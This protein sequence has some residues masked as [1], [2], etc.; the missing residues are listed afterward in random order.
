[1]QG[2]PLYVAHFPLRATITYLN[3]KMLILASMSYLRISAC[4][5]MHQIKLQ[6]VDYYLK[7]RLVSVNK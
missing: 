6:E 5:C 7:E 2:T 4:V 1:M 3:I